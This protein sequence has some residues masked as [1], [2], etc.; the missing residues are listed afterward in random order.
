MEATKNSEKSSVAESDRLNMRIFKE[1]REVST[2]SVDDWPVEQWM[3]NGWALGEATMFR[4][5][6]RGTTWNWQRVPQLQ[7]EEVPS[8]TKRWD[9]WGEDFEDIGNFADGN[10]LQSIE[11]K[12]LRYGEEYEIGSYKGMNRV[13]CGCSLK[14]WV[15]SGLLLVTEVARMHAICNWREMSKA[16]YWVSS[17]ESGRLWLV[18]VLTPFHSIIY[19][20]DQ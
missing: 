6:E 3:T 11:W 9:S 1:W 7:E 8:R 14:W 10:E 2:K 16:I 19:H 17:I 12:G 15:V 5:K 4:E 18:H 13:V 20:R